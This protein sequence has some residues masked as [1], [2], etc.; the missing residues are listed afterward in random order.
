MPLFFISWYSFIHVQQF[1]TSWFSFWYFII[2]LFS[3][4]GMLFSF[5]GMLFSFNSMLFSFDGIFIP[6][7]WAGN[8]VT[9]WISWRMIRRRRRTLQKTKQKKRNGKVPRYALKG[10]RQKDIIL[11]ISLFLSY[12]RCLCPSFFVSSLFFLSF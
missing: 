11:S 1:V 4:D 10:N 8:I 9:G 7:N 3:F 6:R 5:H 12:F 2:M